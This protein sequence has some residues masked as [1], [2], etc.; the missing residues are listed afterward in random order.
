[1]TVCIC[2]TILVLGSGLFVYLFNS[3][4]LVIYYQ[5]LLLLFN[6][7]LHLHLHCYEHV[8]Y[9]IVSY[10][11]MCHLCCF[12]PFFFLNITAVCL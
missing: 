7:R 3:R 6:A 4:H 12:L 8:G 10:H 9:A 5:V 1:M 2:M 11:I